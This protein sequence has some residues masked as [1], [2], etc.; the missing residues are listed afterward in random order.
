[1][2]HSEY[3]RLNSDFT[4]HNRISL[5]LH[6]VDATETFL[7]RRKSALGR[8]RRFDLAITSTL[9]HPTTHAPDD[10][11]WNGQV[12]RPTGFFMTPDLPVSRECLG[13]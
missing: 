13:P 10:P 11:R 7:L 5:L 1:M 2:P 3:T 6:L 12:L 4:P 8:K 9:L